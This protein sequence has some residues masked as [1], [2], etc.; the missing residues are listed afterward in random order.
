MTTSNIPQ[1]IQDKANTMI[2]KGTKMTFDAIC[3]MYMKSEA[4]TA[5]KSDSKKEAA[6]WESR[7]MVSEMKIEGNAS[8]WLAAKNLE[9]AK[10]NLPSSMR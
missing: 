10:N 4:K 6:K 8:D 1:H 7:K 3:E 9:N 2:S 5:K